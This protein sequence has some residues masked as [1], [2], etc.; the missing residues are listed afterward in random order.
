MPTISMFYGIVIYLYFFDNER[1]NLPHIHAKFQD[2]DAS[3]SIEDGDLLSG[4]IPLNKQR[5]VQAW[6]EIH[7]ESLMADWELAV[8][9]LPPFKIEPLK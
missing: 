3:F 5:L 6:I 8:N 9:G 2:Y 1:H 7:R 4:N